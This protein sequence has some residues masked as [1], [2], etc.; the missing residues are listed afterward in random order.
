MVREIDG[1]RMELSIDVEGVRRVHRLSR[2]PTPLASVPSDATAD[3]AAFGETSSQAYETKLWLRRKVRELTRRLDRKV[4][5]KEHH[6]E[7]ERRRR[8]ELRC[9]KLEQYL[10]MRTLQGLLPATLL[11]DYDF[12]QDLSNIDVIRGYPIRPAHHHDLDDVQGMDDAE[13][14]LLE[15]EARQ[16]RLTPQP[17]DNYAQR[18]ELRLLRPSEGHSVYAHYRGSRVFAQVRR[19]PRGEEGFHSPQGKV[20]LSL[21]HAREGSQLHALAKKLSKVEPLSHVLAWASAARLPK[22][23]GKEPP[24]DVDGSL[25]PDLVELPR[26]KMSLR[27]ERRGGEL[28]VYS[29]DHAL[30]Y[31]VDTTTQDE[32]E[33]PAASL[34][35]GASHALLF[36]SQHA[37]YSVMIP[38]SKVVRPRISDRPFTTELMFDRTDARWNRAVTKY[39]LYPVHVS[40]TFLQAGSLSASLYLLV[41]HLTQRNFLRAATLA[42][43]IGTDSALSAEERQLFDL[44]ASKSVDSGHPDFYAVRAKVVLSLSDADEPIPWDMRADQAAYTAKLSHVSARCRLSEADERLALL[45]CDD[46]DK[47]LKICKA[48]MMAN[49]DKPGKW[50][51]EA[52][53]QFR[54]EKKFSP[55][56]VI[57]ALF[58]FIKQR[59]GRIEMPPRDELLLH[60]RR[61]V[62]HVLRREQEPGLSSLD[63]KLKSVKGNMPSAPGVL[64]LNA[65]VSEASYP[66]VI[67]SGMLQYRFYSLDEGFSPEAAVQMLLSLREAMQD[68]GEGM[69]GGKLGYSFMLL[70]DI[71][72]KTKE[73]QFKRMELR[74]QHTFAALMLSMYKDH[75]QH[76]T[77]QAILWTLVRNPWICELMPR[78]DFDS[79]E[80]D[81][82]RLQWSANPAG[83]G[84]LTPLLHEA[85]KV[86]VK[87][88]KRRYLLDYSL[89]KAGL[90]APVVLPLS[91]VIPPHATDPKTEMDYD[92]LPEV[93]HDPPPS[94]VKQPAKAL[95]EPTELLTL[96][97]SAVDEAAVGEEAVQLRPLRWSRR[98]VGRGFGERTAIACGQPSDYRRDSLTLQPLKLGPLEVEQ[99]HLDQLMDRP[100]QVMARLEQLVTTTVA[101]QD[102]SLGELPFDVADHPDA[103]TTLAENALKRL[104]RDMLRFGKQKNSKP[105]ATLVGLDMAELGH[106]PATQAAHKFV[107][108]RTKLRA[109]RAM[110]TQQRQQDSDFVMASSEVVQ[111]VAN[112][113]EMPDGEIVE[114]Q[115]A[116]PTESLFRQR[117]DP[118]EASGAGGAGGAAGNGVNGGNGQGPLAVAA[119]AIDAL[120]GAG[121]SKKAVRI[122]AIGG[123]VGHSLDQVRFMFSNGK[124]IVYGLRDGAEVP[125]E[126][127]KPNEWIVAVAQTVVEKHLGAAMAFT[128]NSGRQIVLAGSHDQEAEKAVFNVANAQTHQLVG[129]E[130]SAKGNMLKSVVSAPVVAV[131]DAP[132]YGLANRYSEPLALTLTFAGLK[133]VNGRYNRDGEQS[134]CVRYVHEGGQYM[135]VKTD[136]LSCG[137][138]YCAKKHGAWIVASAEATVAADGADMGIYYSMSDSQTPPLYGWQLTAIETAPVPKFRVVMEEHAQ[139]LTARQER[140]NRFLLLRHSGQEAHVWIEY[141]IGCLLSSRAAEDLAR[142]N[143][144]VPERL[145]PTLLNL[146]AILLLR[147]N[148]IGQINRALDD[149]DGAL[150]ECEKG[151]QLVA[152]PALQPRDPNSLSEESAPEVLTPFRSASDEPMPARVESGPEPDTTAAAPPMVAR[153]KSHNAGKGQSTRLLLRQRLGKAVQ[154]TSMINRLQAVG[155]SAK[156]IVTGFRLKIDA[157]LEGLLAPR[158]YAS[159]DTDQRR[160]RDLLEKR[161]EEGLEDRERRWLEAFHARREAERAD[162]LALASE[163]DTG[164]TLD[165]RFLVF[166]FVW[167]ML[168]RPRQ[169]DLVLECVHTADKDNGSIVK[170]MI[171]GQG[172]TTVVSPLIC[173]M[174]AHGDYLVVQCVPPALLPMSSSVLRTTFSSI[175]R[176][177]LFT[178]T[179]DRAAVGDPTTISKLQS[180]MA[181]GSIVITTPP[182]LKSLM[183]KF[184]ENLL[185]LTNLRDPRYRHAKELRPETRVWAEVLELM[186]GGVCIMDEVD[187]VLHPLKV[188]AT[189]SP[190][191]TLII[192]PLLSRLIA[193]CCLV[194]PAQSRS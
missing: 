175:I 120:R 166:E 84:A 179:C 77:L 47:K 176:K 62:L 177:R 31:L 162:A 60:N 83:D 168:L 128:L 13:R 28:R 133:A 88:A 106:L 63:V 51:P 108:A 123:R 154:M 130:F 122:V 12:Y 138:Y 15:Q 98:Q 37:E 8:E 143:P 50:L 96:E 66:L 5:I 86:L 163:C 150:K 115:P 182:A 156:A 55:D 99:A 124:E 7:E 89:P 139:R 10:P 34:V 24:L 52:R 170:Q 127:L 188:I 14:H 161:D 97:L 25:V 46:F 1:S 118:P 80:G 190:S 193:R 132:S 180:A 142:L 172:K 67:G 113:V 104:Q 135:I 93:S 56:R 100:L 147:T 9:D 81:G 36:R 167:T 73:I 32:A 91:N 111:M 39:F 125:S 92:S 126:P 33:L 119:A 174:M 38:R 35:G 44:L 64:S 11:E 112:D 110:L 90:A 79:Y 76:G 87:I 189:I 140:A 107:E 121:A 94:G 183:L 187:W 20:L 85:R 18:I 165:P 146:L 48:V 21:M 27:C 22:G 160:E 45:A 17:P 155:P 136:G 95:P 23:K 57:S 173:L 157:L 129:L 49:K 4:R 101:A 54:A 42:S 137:S 178:F 185:V 102:P 68:G 70:Y 149:L 29:V 82:K 116:D 26:L 71:L 43:S 41:L 194:P 16:F 141:A 3:A 40:G 145:R 191:L 6:A 105:L 61:E 58:E 171:M 186:Q 164:Y 59:E 30:L 19:L 114:Q 117:S 152:L 169:V 75:A 53:G 109:L 151:S 192:A 74:H 103:Q 159:A 134:G 158:A 72:T 181:D 2:V 144:L 131:A 148:R 69:T 78:F 65:S 153:A 184:V